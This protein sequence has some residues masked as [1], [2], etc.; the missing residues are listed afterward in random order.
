M[1]SLLQL[2]QETAQQW[3][4]RCRTSTSRD[5]QTVAV[6]TK[7]EGVSFLTITLPRFCDDLQK[8][9]AD[10]KVDRNSFQGFS[11]R[12]GLPAFLGGFL[13][14]IF[15][16]GTGLLLDDPDI[17][18]IRAVRQLT[19]MFG[20]ILLPCTPAR[21]RAAFDAFVEIEK[22]V[23]KFDVE[24]T[25]DD[26][27]QFS[28]IGSLLFGEVLSELDRKVWQGALYPK[29][30]PG[31]TADRLVANAKWTNREWP[32]RLER[33]FPSGEYLF[34]SPKLS[35]ELAR[36]NI[37][38]PGAERP[39]RVISVPKTLKTPRIIAIEPTAMQFMQQG[40]SRD[41]V[42]ALQRSDSRFPW[43]LGFRDSESNQLMA[44]EGSI[45]GEL[46]TLDLSEASDRVSNQLVRS[47]LA[48]FPWL[49]EGVDAC[50][51]RKADVPG[52]GVIRLAKFASMGSALTFPIEAMVFATVVM[53]GIEKE[54]GRQLTLRDVNSLKGQVRVY[55]DDIVVPVRYVHSVVESLETFGFKVNSRKSFWTGSFRESCGKEYYR[56]HDVTVVRVRDLLPTQRRDTARF[57]ATV[58][59]RNRFYMAGQWG[60]AGYLDRLLGGLLKAYPTIGPGAGVLGRWSAVRGWYTHATLTERLHPTLHHRLVTG[61][62]VTPKTPE[63]PLDGIDALHKILS[64]KSAADDLRARARHGNLSNR[65]GQDNRP[66]EEGLP[67][68]DERRWFG[69]HR[70]EWF[71]RL[72][73]PFHDLLAGSEPATDEGHLKYLGRPWAVDIKL[74]HVSPE[75]ETWGALSISGKG[76][77]G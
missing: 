6:R 7:D 54:L 64:S 72:G 23:R 16:R 50:R 33:I 77:Q 61:Y 57:A 45:T 24:R 26:Y 21:E 51:S 55:G 17:E 31:A 10:G 25:D 30:G 9:L 29:H 20:K 68:L 71:Q 60:V 75:G 59:L 62:V 19:L 8:G 12:A 39:V 63:S 46:A 13:D 32:E 56:G 44:L 52:K 66:I 15:D 4:V 5:Y 74:R 3:A 37:L 65:L 35:E 22:D 69:S 38:P 49:N 36:V 34:H 76:R 14:R 40:I 41:L 27:R 58:S 1:Q 70:A 11:W 73:D 2:W 47:L 28:R 18:A 42:E 43:L 67:P 48:P 53:V